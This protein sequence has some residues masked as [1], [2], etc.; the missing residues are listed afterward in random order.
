MSSSIRI[1]GDTRRL[2]NRMKQLADVNKKGL[3]QV[4]AQDIK[5]STR[6]RFRTQKAPDGKKWEPSGRVLKG[7][8][9]T[10]VKS[11][12]LK[13]SIKYT[14]DASGFSVGTNNI[15]AAT[16]Q[17]GDKNRRITIKAKTPKGLLFKIGDQWIRKKQV[18]I[19][20]DIPAR[21]F[22]GLSED[23][24]EEIKATIEDYFKEV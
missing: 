8:G 3:N 13:N 24:M 6:N 21:P 11:A 17:L 22:L 1:D 4:L 18:T 16:H 7:G 9:V 12:V 2:M 10:L 5:T 14:S 23:D 15:Y 19:K 20:V